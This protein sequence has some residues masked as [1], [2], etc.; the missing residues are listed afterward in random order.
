MD[1]GSTDRTVELAR[2]FEPL[3]VKVFTQKNQGASAAR[4]FAF[5]LCK[6]DYIQWLDADDLLGPGKIAK[7]MEVVTRGLS[8]RVL[9][10]GPWGY[11]MYRAN[12]ASFV[13]TALWQDLSPKEWLL[14]KMGQ[15]VFMQT[16][17]WLVSRELTHAAGPRDIRMLG[18]DDGEYFCRVLM[19]S[20]EVRFVSE[21]KCITGRSDSGASVLSAGSLKRSRHIGY[22][23]SCTS[24][25]CVRWEM[26]P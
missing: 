24:N 13:P 22:R 16:A 26:I 19:A 21:S 14:R 10:S 7:Q 23:C 1:D 6:G 17:T 2:R 4:N 15:N 20:E 12:R 3:G 5:Q 8:K 25:I 11:F 9:L 18:D